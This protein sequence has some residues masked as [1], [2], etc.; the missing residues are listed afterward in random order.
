MRDEADQTLKGELVPLPRDA[1][2]GQWTELE[3]ETLLA[4][5]GLGWE[6]R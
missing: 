2:Q 1:R 3:G 4:A 6:V 5:L